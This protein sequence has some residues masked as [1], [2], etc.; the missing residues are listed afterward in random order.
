M[1]GQ[2]EV[3][4]RLGKIAQK[5]LDMTMESASVFEVLDEIG[6]CV[7]VCVCSKLVELC[8]KRDRRKMKRWGPQI[9][10]TEYICII[11]ISQNSESILCITSR[12]SGT[13]MRNRLIST[14]SL[15]VPTHR[16]LGQRSTSMKREEMQSQI[17]T[18]EVKV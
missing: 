8:F 9:V 1:R 16:A 10:L 14:P 3:R 4:Q 13:C 6:S 17:L 5:R 7:C 11:Q 15:N 12:R 2:K 18:R